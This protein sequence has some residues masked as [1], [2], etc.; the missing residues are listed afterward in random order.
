MNIGIFLIVL[1][2]MFW[3]VFAYKKKRKA[4]LVFI[5]TYRF[6]SVIKKKVANK[7]PHLTDQ[8]LMLVIDGLKEYLTICNQANKKQVAM[9]SQVVDVAW[10]EFILFTKEYQQFCDKAFGR[11][12]HHTPTEAM[13][14]PTSAQEGIKRAWR[15]ACARESINP[16][17]PTKLPL[18]FAID[19]KLNIEDGFIYSLDCQNT[20]SATNGI[21]YC[22]SHIGCS[23]GCAGSSCASGDG[24]GG[25][26]GGD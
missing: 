15:L 24:G 21:G 22:A 10:H 6:N 19:A 14:T 17:H 7:Y 1:V 4:Q 13:K 5:G 26:G 23:S 8:D 20:S 11:F 3:G 16:I 9:P 2:S 18:L 25:C 12:L